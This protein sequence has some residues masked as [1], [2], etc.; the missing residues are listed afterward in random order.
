[1]RRV[2]FFRG[3]ERTAPERR[4]ECMGAGVLRDDH[5]A[6]GPRNGDFFTVLRWERSEIL[7]VVRRFDSLH[8]CV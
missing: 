3:T 8:R 6:R 7:Q 1:M 2:R 4:I 5:Q